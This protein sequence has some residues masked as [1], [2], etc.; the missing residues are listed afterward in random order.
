MKKLFSLILALAMVFA[1]AACGSDS[2]SAPAAAGSA[3]AASANGEDAAP[4]ASGQSFNIG[5][6][7]TGSTDATS[8]PLYDSMEQ[9]I[10]ALGC[11][12]IESAMEEDSGDGVLNAV[13]NLLSTGVDG[14]IV[15]NVASM[16]GLIPTI[17]DLCEQNK[18]Y[19]SL[20]WT[21]LD[22]GTEEYDACMNNPYF[23]STTCEDDV[24]SG[25]WAASVV[26]KLGVEKICTITLPDG[27]TTT[28]MRNE[29][30][31]KACKEYNMTVLGSCSDVSLTTSSAGGTTIT[32]DFLAAYPDTEA[33]VVLGMSQYVL[34]GIAQALEDANRTDIQVA[35]IDFNEYQQDYMNS[36]ILDGII[37]GHFAGPTYSV[38]LMVNRLQG[39]PLA[40]SGVILRDSFIELGSAE[41]ADEYATKIYGNCL[42]TDEQLANCLV[43]NN[44]DFTYDDLVAIADAYGLEDILSRTQG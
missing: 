16:Y 22:E 19:F 40:E 37:G 2:G 27:F 4:A 17:A 41:E 18:V 31:E 42:Y 14:L 3:P 8:K 6:V 34:P 38:I 39:N 26:G 29:G 15:P 20:F 43:S 28:N 30:L 23:I 11:N 33:I 35:G 10:K 5:A 9:A 32:E 44:P 21:N 24:Y 36:G 25:Y 13:N 12:Y 7:T 1:L